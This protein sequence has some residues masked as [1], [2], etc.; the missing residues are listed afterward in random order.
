MYSNCLEEK[1]YEVEFEGNAGARSEHA[2]VGVSGEQALKDA[3][4]CETRTALP[5]IEIL[6]SVEGY[7]SG[8]DTVTP[9][10][11]CLKRHG[12]A[13]ETMTAEDYKRIVTDPDLDDEYFGKY[14]NEQRSDYDAEKSP[15]YWAC[16]ANPNA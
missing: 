3:K 4:Q 11:D 14:F 9:L 10:V 8:E 6:H 15:A 2:P 13:D 7:A 16:N 12:I 5:Y 1:G